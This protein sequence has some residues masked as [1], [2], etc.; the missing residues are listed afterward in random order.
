MFKLGFAIWLAANIWATA[1]VSRK[2][3]QTD[4]RIAYYALIWCIPL[5]GAIVAASIAA[6][7]ALRTGE[8]ATEAIP[9]GATE[10]KKRS[11][12]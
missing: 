6:H 2:L 1:F 12:G 10:T 11:R 5:F 3:D 9:K 8:D 4:H 7:R